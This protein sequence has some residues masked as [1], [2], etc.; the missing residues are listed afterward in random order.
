M[1]TVMHIGIYVSISVRY[2]NFGTMAIWGA[3]RTMLHQRNIAE[4]NMAAQVRFGSDLLD[5]LLWSLPTPADVPQHPLD[6]V[7]V[8]TTWQH[9][10][11]GAGKTRQAG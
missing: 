10:Q 7:K 6:Q 4:A 3:I 11:A 2:S 8:D 5:D 9:R 1:Q